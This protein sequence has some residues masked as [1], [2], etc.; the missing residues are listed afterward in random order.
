MA[1]EQIVYHFTDTVRLPW[2]V[3]SKEL[4][5]DYY[6]LGHF[7]CHDFVWATTRPQ[8]DRTATSMWSYRQRVAALVRLTLFAEDFE[9]WPEIIERFPQW[10]MAHVRDFEAAARR[11]GETNT[12]CWRARAEPLSLPRVLRADAKTYTGQW[13]AI[14]LVGGQHPRDPTLRGVVLND[15]VS[16]SRQY[17][18]E[19]QPTGYIPARCQIGAPHE[20]GSPWS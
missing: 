12:N 15:I 5:A 18:R 13:Q 19:G 1:T 16:C 10:T 2:I 11:M 20:P 3:A 14:E 8:G 9:S 4:R 17:V 7:P 6:Q